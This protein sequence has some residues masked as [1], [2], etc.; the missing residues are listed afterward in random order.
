M[1]R[2]LTV[3]A[4]LSSTA[5][6]AHPGVHHLNGVGHSVTGSDT[7]LVVAAVGIWALAQAVMVRAWMKRRESQRKD[8]R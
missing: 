6:W 3:T 4:L 7:W 2:I 1:K 8:R 5:A